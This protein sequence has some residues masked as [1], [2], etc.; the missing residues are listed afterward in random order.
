M[1]SRTKSTSTKRTSAKRRR[2]ARPKVGLDRAEELAR[3]QCSDE[4]LASALGLSSDELAQ[5]RQDDE[6]LCAALARGRQ[7]G[8][9]SLRQA[10]WETALGGNVHMQIWLGKQYLD[11]RDRQEQRLE[12]TL[13]HKHGVDGLSTQK[14][15]A[16]LAGA[17][18]G[19][20]VSGATDEDEA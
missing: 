8:M 13:T 2:S 4:E 16:I 10:Q 12:G 9:N 19:R 3:L 20:R 15:D 6:A 11:Q 14:L 7:E 18:R 1:A 5:L 17:L